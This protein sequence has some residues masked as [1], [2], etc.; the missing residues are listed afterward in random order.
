MKRLAL[1]SVLMFIGVAPAI[2]QVSPKIAKTPSAKTGAKGTFD[3]LPGLSGMWWHN[4][5]YVT[6]L[7][8]TTDQQSKM[9]DVFQSSRIKLID[10]NA[11]V[12]KEEATLRPL[13]ESEQLDEAK[14]LA[15]ID[16][17]AQARAELEKGNA[18]MLVG[19]RQVLTAQQWSQLQRGTFKKL[20][21]QK[22]KPEKVKAFKPVN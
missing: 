19:F 3:I 20:N 7:Q 16:R 9:D 6:A 12:E 13:L 4:P 15:Q 17:V 21:V 11:S 22:I 8:L 14:V 10:L 1:L 5:K 18:R 2:A